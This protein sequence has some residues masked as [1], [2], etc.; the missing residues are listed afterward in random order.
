MD[1]RENCNMWLES[2]A[3]DDDTKSELKA[4]ADNE[5]ETEDRFYRNLAFGTGGLRGIMGAGTNRMNVYTV[6][7]ATQGLAGEILSK[8]KEF[9]G[10][11]VVIAY[12]SRNNSEKFAYECTRVLG[13]NGIKT[14][15]FDSLR[16][17]PELSFAV[18]YLGCARGIVITASHNPKEYN[19]YKVY[20]EDGGQ[21]PPETAKTIQTFID[22]IHIFDDVKLIDKPDNTIIGEDVDRAYIDAVKA[23]SCKT[24]VPEDFR[25]VYTPLHGSGNLLVRRILSEI[26]VK[27]VF[28]VP[29]Q[30]MPNG[31][32]PTVKSPNPEN[33]EAF[34]IAVEYAKQQNADIVFGTDPDS[35][36]LG[37]VVR[38]ANG[39]YVVLNGNQTGCLLCEYI[40]R[41]AKEN[42]TFTQNGA[43]VK[44]IVTT[45]MVRAIAA[46]YGTE[47]IDVLTGFKFIGDQIKG[48]EQNG[49][50]E[51]FIF[52]LE[53]SY[54]YLKG[55]YA[56]DKDAVVAAMLICEAAADYKAKG[57][58]LYEGLKSLYDKYGYYLESLKTITLTGIDGA[59]KIKEI[60]SKFRS[61]SLPLDIVKKLD[62]LDGIDG[63]PK[64]DVLKFFTPNGWFAVRPSGTEPKIKF[65]FGIRAADPDSAKSQLE[66]MISS[67]WELL[68]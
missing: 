43:V 23:Q 51:K 37:V 12:D 54:G 35:D 11:G 45:E 26:G 17:T 44:T 55:T 38:N 8:G 52:G 42:G 40:L 9:A 29:E 68:A 22:G 60:M 10:K 57:M 53:E 31:D 48:F 47:T 5:K 41:K 19:G 36:R 33:S 56:R 6:R 67:V 30:E 64:S 20:G 14:Y 27:N 63:L 25:A 3:V 16:P 21:I 65:Y 50:P 66:Q 46:D 61:G 18:R 49:H 28:T 39:E 62:Y 13:A 2:K 34:D 58:T 1:Y 32:F 4:I 15:I 24:A 59:E 7:K